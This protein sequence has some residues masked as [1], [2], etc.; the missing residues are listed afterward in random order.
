MDTTESMQRALM[1][2]A[3]LSVLEASP[4]HG[5]ALVAALREVGFANAQGGTVYPMLRAMEGDGLVLS[6]WDV[7][8]TGPARKVFR[9]TESGAGRVARDRIAVQHALESIDHLRNGRTSA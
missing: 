1:P 8:G 3:V 5:Y 2:L 6:E 9:L 4:A 7:T